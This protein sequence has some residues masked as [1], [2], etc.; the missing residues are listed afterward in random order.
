MDY[1]KIHV[2]STEDEMPDF[3]PGVG[4]RVLIDGRIFPSSNYYLEVDSFFKALSG[5]VWVEFVGGC[6]IKECCGSGARTEIT[7]AGWIW[8]QG[9]YCFKWSDVLGASRAIVKVIQRYEGPKS[10][11]WGTQPENMQFYQQQLTEL[12]ARA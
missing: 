6:H 3:L 2:E 10:E 1:N 4:I 7:K 8:N 11:V 9:K 5:E 12:K